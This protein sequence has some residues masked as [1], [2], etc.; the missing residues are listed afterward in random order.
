MI[1]RMSSE[2]LNNY[3]NPLCCYSKSIAQNIIYTAYLQTCFNDLLYNTSNLKRNI[4]LFSFRLLSDYNTILFIFITILFFHRQTTSLFLSA[5]IHK[6][7]GYYSS[8]IGLVK[9]AH[10]SCLGSQQF[11]LWYEQPELCDSLVVSCCENHRELN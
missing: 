11:R 9:D 2:K 6:C 8:F 3:E 1:Y 4:F 7:F 5:Y 10:S